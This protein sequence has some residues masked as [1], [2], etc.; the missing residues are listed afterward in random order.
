MST[1]GPAAPAS[2]PLRAGQVRGGGLGARRAG[3]GR[4]EVSRGGAIEGPVDGVRQGSTRLL[5]TAPRFLD[6]NL[7]DNYC[8]NPDGSERPWCYTTDQQMEREFCDLPRCG[9]AWGR[10]LGGH[11]G[12][13]GAWPRGERRGWA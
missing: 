1:L 6:K 8:R 9:I 3:K 12:Y 5:F 7:D 2:T 11:L 10:G 4:V 13:V